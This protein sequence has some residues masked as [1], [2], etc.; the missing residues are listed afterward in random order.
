MEP[1]TFK[2][3]VM[4]LNTKNANIVRDYYLNLEE[5]M[6]AYGKYT[7]KYMMDKNNKQY[8]KYYSSCYHV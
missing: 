8:K 7:L 1:R 4:R 2:N 3:V 6:F 5:A